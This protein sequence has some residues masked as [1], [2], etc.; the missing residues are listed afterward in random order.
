[1][2]RAFAA[3]E[4]ALAAAD[5]IDFDDLVAGALRA[6]EGDPALLARW[7]T[8]CAHLLVDE[9]QDV[10]RSQLRLALLLAAPAN[11]VFLVGDDDQSIYGWRLADVRRVLGLAAD[12]PGLRRVDLAVNYRCPGAVLARAVRLVEHNQERFAKSIQPGPDASGRLILAPAPVDVDPL[13]RLL[14]TWPA[15]GSSRAVLARTR[16][17]LLPAVAACLTGGIAF[18]ADGVPLPL[19][20]ARVDGLVAAAASS[21]SPLPIAARV[22]AAARA[23]GVPPPV[24][25]TPDDPD[26]EPA[27]TDAEIAAAVTAWAV[28]IAPDDDLAGAIAR[29]RARLAELRRPDAALTLATAHATKGL[30]WDHVAV[31]G[32]TEGRFPSARS[33]TDATDPVRALEE[34]RRL[35]YVAWTRARRS[36]TLVYDP[37]APSPFMLEAFDAAEMGG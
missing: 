3:Y 22:A 33:L 35:A 23:G 26:P 31:L 1:V 12:L 34:E 5:A 9:V 24:A 25:P 6:L 4:R 37:A 36:L 32:M 18:R 2:T 19:E 29:A 30:E 11:R 16:R 21:P 7:R 13:P 17:E 15:D 28:R 27:R 20:D 10:D 14:A 8:R